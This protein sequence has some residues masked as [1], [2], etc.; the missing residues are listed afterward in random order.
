HGKTFRLPETNAILQFLEETFCAIP[1]YKDRSPLDKAKVNAVKDASLMFIDFF[2]EFYWAENWTEADALQRREARSHTWLE[3]M[4][5]YLKTIDTALLLTDPIEGA[6]T[7]L[8]AA[9]AVLFEALEIVDNQFPGAVTKHPEVAAIHSKI[10]NRPR[11]AEYLKAGKREALITLSS[12]ET[13]EKR[14]AATETWKAAA[15]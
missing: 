11:V 8:T 10:L 7:T 4:D 12:L 14:A 13:A 2:W 5:N 6:G 1:A 15:K 9:A 3:Q